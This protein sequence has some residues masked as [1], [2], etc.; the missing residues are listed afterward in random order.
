MSWLG[1]HPT[2]AVNTTVENLTLDSEALRKAI[3]AARNVGDVPVN[4]RSVM[5]VP[6]AWR[7]ITMLSF[8]VASFPFAL[9]RREPDGTP[10]EEIFN[11]PVARAFNRKANPRQSAFE[12]R[13]LMQTH[14][15]LRGNAFARINTTL[16]NDE[17]SFIPYQLDRVTPRLTSD[18][19]EIEFVIKQGRNQRDRVLPQSEVLH[20][21]GMSIDG[22]EGL[23]PIE[24]ARLTFAKSLEGQNASMRI[25]QNGTFAGFGLKHPG[26]LSDKAHENIQNSFVDRV[27][28]SKNA[29]TPPIFEEGLEPVTLGFNATDAQFL[30]G[31]RFSLGDIGRLYGVPGHLLGDTE[32]ST[33]WGTGLSEQTQGFVSFNLM[34]WVLVFESAIDFQLL[35]DERLFPK[36]RSDAIARGD[37]K[38]RAA[39]YKDMRLIGGMNANEVRRAEDM[40]SRTDEGGSEY[41]TPSGAMLSPMPQEGSQDDES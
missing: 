24:V 27:A 7:A 16:R 32:K 34:D 28:G 10:G 17:I 8:L 5:A 39:Y 25:L 40:P 2:N 9:I 30:E 21:R 29:G 33:T 26:K 37:P 14:L 13:R 22:V 20:F 36:L 35:D 15:C 4:D 3:A 31:Q 19:T 41:L 23:S 38:A 11:H 6:A 12:F 1:N 18:N